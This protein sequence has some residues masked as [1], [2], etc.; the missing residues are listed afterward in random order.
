MTAALLGKLGFSNQAPAKTPCAM[1]SLSPLQ[2]SPAVSA[3]EAGDDED[4]ENWLEN[5]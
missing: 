4:F 1:S 5:A 3:S 2:C